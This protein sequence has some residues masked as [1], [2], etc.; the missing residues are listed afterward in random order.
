M[1]VETYKEV[2]TDVQTNI[3]AVLLII[4]VV[5]FTCFTVEF[6]NENQRKK[7]EKSKPLDMQLTFSDI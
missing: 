4:S 3:L 5:C 2:G 7:V 1:D 6:K